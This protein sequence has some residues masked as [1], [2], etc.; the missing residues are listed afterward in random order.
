M[1]YEPIWEYQGHKLVRRPDSKN[2]YITWCRPGSRRPKKR[3]TKTSNVDLAKQRLVEFV[4][5]RISLGPTPPEQ[6]DLIGLLKSYVER[7]IRGKRLGTAE[8]TALKH[9]T[10]FLASHDIATVAE[11][12]RSAQERYIEWRQQDLKARGYTGSNGTLSRERRVMRAALNDAWREGLLTH[13]P[14]VQSVPEPPPR[15]HF[16]FPEEFAYVRISL[17][18]AYSNPLPWCLTR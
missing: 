13:P 6:L 16:L 5:Q 12:T 2:L 4:Q 14:Y 10:A 3:S 1:F 7:T 9:W 11:L 18:W 15:Q 17:C 8:E